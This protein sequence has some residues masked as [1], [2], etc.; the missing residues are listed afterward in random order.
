METAVASQKIDHVLVGL[1]QTDQ[2]ELSAALDRILAVEAE[3]VITKILRYRIQSLVNPGAPKGDLEDVHSEVVLRLLTRLQDFLGNPEERGIGDFCKYVAVV[4][5][6]ACNDYFR[7]RFPERSRLKNRLRYLLKHHDA[8]TL[9]ESED[10]EWLCGLVQWRGKSP[11]RTEKFQQLQNNPSSLELAESLKGNLTT[12]VKEI[13]V[14][15][16]H[17]LQLDDLVSISATLLG[18]HEKL[19]Q[20]DP[21]QIERLPDSRK[22]MESVED[23]EAYLKQLWEEIQ[24]L[25]VRQRKALLLNLRDAAGLNLIPLFPQTGIAGIREIASVLE[26]SD[27]DFATLWIE[28]PMEDTKIAMILSLTRQQV[29]NLRKSARERLAR[30][31]KSFEQQGKIF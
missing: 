23:H 7:E 8:F 11:V 19:T 16:E 24:K 29:I 20:N 9:W 26:M 25:P 18:I 31:M 6:N 4:T 21:G 2:A 27:I 3:P 13:F 22:E 1:L 5:H 14:Y 15:L 10:Q 30:R 12:F 28:L 17:P